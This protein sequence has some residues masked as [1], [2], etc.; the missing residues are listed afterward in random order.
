MWHLVLPIVNIPRGRKQKTP[1]ELRAAGGT[2]IVSCLLNATD[3]S[4][5]R[6]HVD[7]RG[8]RDS[9]LLLGEV[10]L[11]ESTG[12]GRCHC[13]IFGKYS[14]PPLPSL[15]PPPFPG[16]SLFSPPQA[17]GRICGR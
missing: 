11:Q 15:I 3:Q 2:V 12:A 5:H 9:L 14:L 1:G 7:S 17:Q 4:S 8:P 16:S 13:A 10:T 6:A